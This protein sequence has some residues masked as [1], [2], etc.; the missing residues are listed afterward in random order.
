MRF[1]FDFSINDSQVSQGILIKDKS[2]GITRLNNDQVSPIYI[3]SSYKTTIKIFNRFNELINLTLTKEVFVCIKGF[4][5][6]SNC[7]SEY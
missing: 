1:S 4:S 2:L 6:Y 5:F 7:P 3:G